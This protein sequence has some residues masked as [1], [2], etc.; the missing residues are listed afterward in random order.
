MREG[1]KG[2]GDLRRSSVSDFFLFSPRM[3]AS[4]MPAP[5]HCEL[6]YPLA[7]DLLGSALN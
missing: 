3:H 5:K 4:D 2:S 7:G 1:G 6:F